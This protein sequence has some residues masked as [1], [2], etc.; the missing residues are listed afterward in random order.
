ME[1]IEKYKIFIC[2]KKI[3]KL[4][5]EPPKLLHKNLLNTN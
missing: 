1:S 5:L 3:D 4:L 2:I